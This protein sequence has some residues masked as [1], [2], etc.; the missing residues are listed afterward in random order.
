MAATEAAADG[1]PE[2]MDTGEAAGGRDADEVP[3]APA[4][5]EGEMANEGV[6]ESKPDTPNPPKL[7]KKPYR[8]VH[9]GWED[10]DALIRA[11]PMKG[12]LARNA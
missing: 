12:L 1:H 5:G 9:A 8:T 6:V 11:T 7:P 4:I 3:V 2:A 10:V